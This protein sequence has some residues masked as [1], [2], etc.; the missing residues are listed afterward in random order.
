MARRLRRRLRCRKSPT[1]VSLFAQR[2]DLRL[3]PPCRTMPST[4]KERKVYDPTVDDANAL[5]CNLA[6]FQGQLDEEDED[7]PTGLIS[8]DGQSRLGL[9]T[10][11]GSG[12][13]NCG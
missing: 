9:R 11:F 5:L 7:L 10:A 1:N 2:G 4:K 3:S 13:A 6:E 12:S 8:G